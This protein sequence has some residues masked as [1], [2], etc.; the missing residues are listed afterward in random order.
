MKSAKT[1]E[2]GSSAVAESAD[3]KEKV[4]EAKDV[5]EPEVKEGKSSK[6][7]KV[8]SRTPTPVS[9][10]PGEGLKSPAAAESS[11]SAAVPVVVEKKDALASESSEKHKKVST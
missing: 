4:K 1:T 8:N 7:R 2:E 6:K 3:S 9:V 10:V 11:A 5:A